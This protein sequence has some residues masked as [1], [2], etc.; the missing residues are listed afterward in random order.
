MGE[1]ADIGSLRSR[2]AALVDEEGLL[3]S[4]A[5]A[6]GR[7]GTGSAETAL[8]FARI[9]A[10]HAERGELQKVLRHLLGTRRMHVAAEMWQPGLYDYFAEV[11]CRPLRV[12]V[13]QGTAGLEVLM[14]A[15]NAPV[16]V[17]A[18]QGAFDGP[19]EIDA[20]DRP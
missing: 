16:P 14:P 3:L 20:P 4:R 13:M 17:H 1:K 5:G 2:I 6:S 19:V 12:R 7:R 18:L 15:N 11:G 9:E 8:L 10:L